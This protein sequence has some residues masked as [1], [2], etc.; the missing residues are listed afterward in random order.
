MTK[1]ENFRSFNLYN[2]S[3]DLTMTVRQA[4]NIYKANL[5]E[6]EISILNKNAVIIP[7]KIAAAISQVNMKERF[8]KLNE[9]KSTL[10]QLEMIMLELKKR[11]KID[12]QSWREV[13]DYLMEV[14]KLLNGYFSWI[15]RRKPK[16]K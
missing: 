5:T 4:T 9:A 6:Q 3:T 16:S 15:S 2:R 12:E 10:I 14:M 1:V 7:K 13:D 8:K 11:K